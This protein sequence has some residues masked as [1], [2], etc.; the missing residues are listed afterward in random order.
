MD[1]IPEEFP[2]LRAVPKARAKPLLANLG[3]RNAL[4]DLDLR[5]VEEVHADH[6][7]RNLLG[8][9]EPD[10]S[11]DD[12][13]EEEVKALKQ[14]MDWSKWRNDA[15]YRAQVLFDNCY[16]ELGVPETVQCDADLS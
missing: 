9:D 8:P 15:A 6:V 13:T 11:P 4:V 1:K 2:D 3:F 14:D 5:N 16:K 7:M 10:F 12:P